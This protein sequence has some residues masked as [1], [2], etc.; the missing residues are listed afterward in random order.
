MKEGRQKVKAFIL[1]KADRPEQTVCRIE[2]FLEPL[3]GGS[4]AQPRSWWASQNND[5][6]MRRARWR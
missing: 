4:T 1:I 2:E 5:S 6:R 3:G